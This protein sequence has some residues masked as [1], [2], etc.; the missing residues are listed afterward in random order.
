MSRRGLWSFIFVLIL[1][2]SPTSC[3]GGTERSARD[4]DL[5][6]ISADELVRVKRV[7]DGD[8][9]LLE[10]GRKVRYLGI[11]APEYQEPFYLKAKRL[12]ESLVMGREIRLEFD[13]ERTDGYGRVLAY[14]YAGDE[15]VNARLVQEGLAHAFFIGPNRK[16]NALLLRLQAEAQLHKVGIWSTRGRA[17]NLKITNVH[18]ADPTKGDQYPSYARIVNLSNAS[19]RLAGYVL[20]SE[21]GHRYLFPDVSVEP[22]Y[23]VIVSNECEPDGVKARGQLVVHWCSEGPVWDPSEDTA[24]LTDPRG[25]LEDTFHYK[26]K[27]VRRSASNSKDKNR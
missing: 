11:N 18:S 21:G 3:R 25:N 8:T 22:G 23:T 19:I 2:L 7:Y 9:L 4:E 16:H 15:M 10:D 20:S 12:N 1:L 26:G 13:R 27:R 14:V 24:F 5:A 17:R 6:P